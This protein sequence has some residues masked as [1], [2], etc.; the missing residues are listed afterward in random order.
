MSK[1][2]EAMEHVKVD[3]AMKQRIL[4]N[5]GKELENK[6]VSSFPERTV[7]NFESAKMKRDRF[8]DGFRRYA[9]LAAMFAVLIVGAAAVMQITGDH[10]EMATSP[11]Y[12]SAQSEGAV[13]EAAGEDAYQAEAE[14]AEES[15]D[16]I[17][18]ETELAEES[19][20]QAEAETD[21]LDE[22]SLLTEGEAADTG[23]N[24]GVAQ[25]AENEAMAE[26]ADTSAPA[27]NAASGP[28]E[29]TASSGMSSVADLSPD[30]NAAESVTVAEPVQEVEPVRSTARPVMAVLGIIL[31]LLT[32]AILAAILYRKH[33]KKKH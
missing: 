21:M 8:R 33:G 2:E 24:K 10:R 15:V 29:D 18:T 31:V 14:I 5:L 12:E 6:D 11:S 7:E 16:R 30:K 25:K 9:G 13:M 27:E 1:Y 4:Q 26:S 19:G 17:E 32:I 20:L 28:S 23:A 22:S 3:D